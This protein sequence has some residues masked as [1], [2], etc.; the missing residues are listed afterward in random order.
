MRHGSKEKLCSHDG[1][2]KFSRRG[3]VCI[4]HGSKAK[5]CS[6]EGCTKNVKWGGFC[7]SHR[8]NFE[9][10]SHEG[11][12]ETVF[13]R[14]LCW[15][16]RAKPLVVPPGKVEGFPKPAEGCE[17]TTAGAIARRDGGFGVYNSQTIIISAA[18][19]PSPSIF[20]STTA[21]NFDNDDD[22][23][24]SA[25]IWRSSRTTKLVS[26]SDALEVGV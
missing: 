26:A 6:H 21:P 8:A 20:S 13:S 5:Q 9:L 18:H 25:W 7:W 23:E 10:C 22:D 24:I 2:T 16:H 15:R 17:A 14:G 11:C 3:G 12:A 1:C 4:S 19:H